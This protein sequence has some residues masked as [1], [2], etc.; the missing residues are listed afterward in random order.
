MPPTSA[1]ASSYD[2]SCAWSFNQ[3]F[4]CY[5]GVWER[6]SGK[7]YQR[8]LPKGK[9]ESHH[10][11]FT[12]EAAPAFASHVSELEREGVIGP[13]DELWF[14]EKATGS[15][16]FTAGVLDH[17]REHYPAYYARMRVVLSDVSAQV[18]A[19]AARELERRGFLS[20]RDDGPRIYFHD[21]SLSAEPVIRLA[22]GSIMPLKGRFLYFRH[23]NFFDQLPTRLFAKRNGCF[24]EVYVQ[25]VIAR[26]RLEILE[27]RHGFTRAALLAVI[28]GG[29]DLNALAAADQARMI[30]FRSDV[31]AAMKM[32]ESYRAVENFAEFHPHGTALSR[33]LAGLDEV[34]LV[35]SDAAVAMLLADMELLHPE[36][37]YACFTD[38]SLQRV[39]E[40]QER[41]VELAKYD[42]GVWVGTNAVLMTELLDR[43]GYDA[44]FYPVELTLGEPTPVYTL[45][46]RKRQTTQFEL[47]APL[48]QE[49]TGIE[50]TALKD[51]ALDGLP[52]RMRNN[53]RELAA[54][55]PRLAG[56]SDWRSMLAE[57]LELTALLREFYYRAAAAMTAH[58]PFIKLAAL[59]AELLC[60]YPGRP[61]RIAPEVGVGELKDLE[62]FLGHRPITEPVLDLIEHGGD[63]D[64]VL[65]LGLRLPT[66]ARRLES[67]Q[68]VVLAEVDLPRNLSA[69]QLR[70]RIFQLQPHVDAV[71]ITSGRLADPRFPRSGD[72]LE[73]SLL[74]AL[75]PDRLV[76]I[77][78]MRDR[79]AEEVERDLRAFERRGVR[80]FC[81]VTGD[82]DRN[83][84]WWLDSPHGIQIADR[85]RNEDGAVGRIY[86]DSGSLVAGAM[87][88]S[89]IPDLRSRVERDVVLK[90]RAG[91][92]V[93]FA[94]P[95][96]DLDRAARTLQIISD[97]GLDRHVHIV[98]E[99]LPI[100]TIDQIRSLSEAP[101]IIVP[102]R[103]AAAYRR[104]SS[105]VETLCEPSGAGG[106]SARRDQFADQLF[107]GAPAVLGCENLLTAELA[108]EIHPEMSAAMESAQRKAPHGREA[109]QALRAARDY[110][111]LEVAFAYLRRAMATLRRHPAV[112]GFLIA[113]RNGRELKRLSAEA[114]GLSAESGR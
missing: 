108:A 87:A 74:D 107:R 39:N 81:I 47:S 94:Q 13:G 78:E 48:V 66:L 8:E 70:R 35:S 29:M 38:V 30:G 85:L 91:V 9:S 84:Q 14:H 40:F 113:A 64:G 41:W 43:G 22:D 62:D 56:D 112:S 82:F 52:R 44:S 96:Y 6:V 98:P 89:G 104:I 76:I 103:M 88:W 2:R 92:D 83:S 95:V 12:G 86:A 73:S 21:L 20:Q 37:G 101:G 77:L 100:A 25:A 55:L 19:L 65:T 90:L 110:V 28:G 10:A 111:L 46:V 99:L 45:T 114:R 106:E 102:D 67:G 57:S 93:L 60:R 32:R 34:R 109:A 79:R 16:E 58:S 11:E 54:Q 24:H 36:Y 31:W 50:R 49:L 18:L 97:Y 4:W 7:D 71:S 42:N 23:A 59:I 51:I 3:A 72:L 69:E 75:Q 33:M 15:G 17:L 63:D 61:I 105:N 26:K 68:F 80:N 53:L 27:E 1:S 5:L